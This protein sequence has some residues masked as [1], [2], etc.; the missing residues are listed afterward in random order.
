MNAFCVYQSAYATTKG[1]KTLP[2]LIL[3]K[4]QLS[5]YHCLKREI[6]LLSERLSSLD[7]EVTDTVIGSNS[8]FPFQKMHITIRGKETQTDYTTALKKLLTQRL[9][10]SIESLYKIE[11]FIST[12][13]DDRVRY[14]FTRRYI[15][16]A[17]WKRISAEMG[18]NDESYARKIHDRYIKRYF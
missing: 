1:A 18:S 6:K 16:K 11:S 8:S 17:S 13:E 9:N 12:I 3:T 14:V 2:N 10:K 4:E 5:Q 7:D 15:D